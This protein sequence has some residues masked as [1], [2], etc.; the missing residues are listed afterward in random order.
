MRPMTSITC[1]LAVA[2]I[3]LCL[4]GGPAFAGSEYLPVD[5]YVFLDPAIVDRPLE[6]PFCFDPLN[7]YYREDFMSNPTGGKPDPLVSASVQEWCNYLG[8]SVDEDLWASVVT[9]ASINDLERVIGRLRNEPNADVPEPYAKLGSYADTARMIGAL[10]YL[11][12]AK[13]IDPLAVEPAISRNA[14]DSPSAS[15]V[16]A[17]RLRRE[18]AAAPLAQN[19]ERALASTTDP[20]L[21]QRYAYQAVRLRF[22]SGNRYGC[23]DAF[24][25]HRNELGNSG[26]PYWR[27]LAYVAGAHYQARQYTDANVLFARIFDGFPP[28]RKTA[29]WSFHPQNE[30]DWRQALELASTVREKTVLWQ[31]LGIGHDGMRAMR[32]IRKL[33][34]KSDLLPLLVVREVNR[35]EYEKNVRS[36]LGFPMSSNSEALA[37]CLFVESCA[38]EG[39]VAMPAVWFVAAAHLNAMAGDRERAEL[40]LAR[41]ATFGP[42]SLALQRQIRL[43]KLFAAINTMKTV[44]P[45]Q[46]PWLAS[47]LSWVED[48]VATDKDLRYDAFLGWARDALAKCYAGKNDYVR[49][50]CLR[51]GPSMAYATVTGINEIIALLDKPD[52]TPIEE[53]IC[54]SYS[55]SRDDLVEIKAL[56]ALYDGDIHTA[57]SRIA[58]LNTAV[59]RADPF[60][61]RMNDCRDCDAAD[62][63]QSEYTKAAFVD[64]LDKRLRS[65]ESGAPTAAQDWFEVG[66]A[67]YNITCYGNASDMY[68]DLMPQ[69]APRE[70]G[71]SHR[72]SLPGQMERAEECYRKAYDASND[73]EFRAKAAFMAAKC[74]QNVFFNRQREMD[75]DFRAGKWFRLLR[76][77]YADTRY[78]AEVIQECGYFRTYMGK[79][80]GR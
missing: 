66:N 22:Y 20:F 1:F 17:D 30:S 43:T 9:E 41:A 53:F 23:L 3:V 52:K 69:F 46:E 29:Y 2:S 16:E 38:N 59:L 55:G 36:E 77:S 70:A 73:R 24:Q 48:R 68:S 50:A 26:S 57:A 28:L 47:A 10:K 8:E 37:I 40:E 79:A 56:M 58:G 67:L 65:A 44:D 4:P 76:E 11:V 21:R 60:S 39:N 6:R 35:I 5:A 62:K 7:S 13:E 27:A 49:E 78:V 42:R 51:N 54:R 15:E 12:L 63:S 72:N 31:L 64:R 14:W 74:E 45:A 33:D 19:V 18:N 80:G 71:Q 75:P 25:S 32:E 61:S 34:P